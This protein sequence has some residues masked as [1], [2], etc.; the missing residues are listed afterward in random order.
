M[1]VR[2]KRDC[3]FRNWQNDTNNSIV[4][5]YCTGWTRKDL[6]YKRENHLSSGYG[7][8]SQDSFRNDQVEATKIRGATRSILFP[9]KGSNV[10][11]VVESMIKI[12]LGPAEER[13]ANL[14]VVYHGI[15]S[16]L[17]LCVNI[18]ISGFGTQAN[19]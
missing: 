2:L 1:C 19:L 5:T 15:I 14:S 7:T 16:P 10:R 6:I 8:G 13:F 3:C 18:Y 17:L 12:L 9:A 11:G 4:V